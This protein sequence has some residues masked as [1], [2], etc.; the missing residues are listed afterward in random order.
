[1]ASRTNGRIF[2]DHGE[3]PFPKDETYF[4]DNCHGRFASHEQQ[5]WSRV[6][7]TARRPLPTGRQAFRLESEGYIKFLRQTT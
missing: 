6:K 3:L 7:V 4:I 5:K 2:I 1:M